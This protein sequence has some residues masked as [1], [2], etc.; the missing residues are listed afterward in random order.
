MVNFPKY[1]H[2]SQGLSGLPLYLSYYNQLKLPDIESLKKKNLGKNQDGKHLI[3]NIHKNRYW[4]FRTVQ[5]TNNHIN[6]H[7]SVCTHHLSS[8][9]LPCFRCP[10][11]YLQKVFSSYVLDLY[12][13]LLLRG[14][15][16]P[17]TF[18]SVCLLIY[19]LMINFSKTNQFLQL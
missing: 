4:S 11:S 3:F 14:H 8:L 13:L 5:K 2:F 17:A 9:L 15:F 16:S 12:S 18:M 19:V 6:I 10:S 1:L 7:P